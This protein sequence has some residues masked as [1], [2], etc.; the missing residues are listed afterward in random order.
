VAAFIFKCLGCCSWA[1][2]SHVHVQTHVL[3]L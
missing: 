2:D 1:H 3:E